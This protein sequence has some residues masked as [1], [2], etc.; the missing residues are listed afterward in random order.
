[1][2]KQNIGT[3]NAMVRITFGLFFITYGA[4]R[5]TKRPWSQRYW[6]IILVSAMKVAEGIVKYCPVTDMV[7]QQVETKFPFSLMT[8]SNSKSDSSSNESSNASSHSEN[9][10]SS[11]STTDK[12]EAIEKAAE[13][14][15]PS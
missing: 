9:D 14:I 15:N 10:H 11:N 5:V 12:A 13:N 7:K 8:S 4:V 3:I 6:L 1:M 2:G